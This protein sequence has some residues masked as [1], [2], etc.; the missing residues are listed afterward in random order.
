MIQGV[1][2]VSLGVCLGAALN[3]FVLEAAGSSGP[4]FLFLLALCLYPLTFLRSLSRLLFVP[5]LVASFILVAV[6]STTASLTAV[7]STLICFLLGGAISLGVNVLVFPT[8]ASSLLR[9]KMAGVLSKARELQLMNVRILTNMEKDGQAIQ[10]HLSELAAFSSGL[11][12][13]RESVDAAKF[14]ITFTHYTAPEY[15]TICAHIRVLVLIITAFKRTYPIF[16]DTFSDA[17][18]HKI[19]D[20][21]TP[22]INELSEEVD[23]HLDRISRIINHRDFSLTPLNIEKINRTLCS[24]NNKILPG[25][26]PFLQ[27]KPSSETSPLMEDIRL[28]KLDNELPHAEGSEKEVEW[29]RVYQAH[30]FIFFL[31]AFARQ[32]VLL[33]ES[34]NKMKFKRRLHFPLQLLFIKLGKEIVNGFH[35]NSVKYRTAD[36][37]V[38]SGIA[39]ESN[40][41][42]MKV[43]YYL[44]RVYSLIT[45]PAGKYAFKNTL[46]VI[47]LVMLRFL[48]PDT[49]AFYAKW[50]LDWSISTIVVSMGPS[51]GLQNVKIIFLLIGTSIG[52]FWSY[53]T[54]MAFPDSAEGR[55]F[56]MC[57]IATISFYLQTKAKI[58]FEVSLITLMSVSII[59]F[60]A[61]LIRYSVWQFAYTRLV[62]VL[63]GLAT[64][65]VFT[66]FVWP[67]FVR[68]NVRK[69]ASELVDRARI[70]FLLLESKIDSETHFDP[71]DENISPN[72]H[73]QTKQQIWAKNERILKLEKSLTI[74][75]LEASQQ[76]AMIPTE[77]RL[78]SPFPIDKYGK[79][80][81][82]LGDCSR[83]LL[84]ARFASNFSYAEIPPVSPLYSQKNLSL[85][86]STSRASLNTLT[87]QSPRQ[88]ESQEEF[89]GFGKHLNEKFTKFGPERSEYRTQI[90]LYMYVLSTAFLRKDPLY[91]AVM[92]IKRARKRRARIYARL[93]KEVDW[94]QIDGLSFLCFASYLTS[95]RGF[96][97][98]IESL[99]S[100]I[101]EVFRDPREQN[102]Q[103]LSE[104]NS[105]L[106]RFALNP[107][108]V[109]D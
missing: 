60:G 3:V 9:K 71:T 108:D 82:L 28:D 72:Q 24:I 67:T 41:S 14:E 106:R 102:D 15:E 93:V 35:H 84:S 89:Y 64:A 81:S 86:M 97:L 94:S 83:D 42:L 59:L 69:T 100:T 10:N 101:S 61:Y 63:L 30:Y 88:S 62:G 17:R 80:F 76:L 8:L 38:E 19:I 90:Q 16:V 58:F 54:W 77:P 45:S 1:I 39:E 33:C 107:E 65:I 105:D 70:L 21:V 73:Q 66:Y 92:N 53:A 23:N 98:S 40:S 78:R 34:L 56:M 75:I 27:Q 96:S 51:I 74:K 37:D 13:L 29:A 11:L 50:R 25:L 46:A 68:I 47:L 55:T 43:R 87:S 6:T 36:T 32:V 44:W 95:L 104:I 52:V 22:E 31:E 26:Q 109:D 2:L 5:C 7:R 57:L 79:I 49:L 12:E 99:K 4:L 103:L 18:Y 48:D 20:N 85:F 91:F